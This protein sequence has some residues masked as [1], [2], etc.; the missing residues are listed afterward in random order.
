MDTEFMKLPI[1]VVVITKDESCNIERCL[2]SIPWASELLVVDSDSSDDTVSKAQALG[3]RVLIEPWRGFG[4]QKAFAARAATHDWILSLDA[5]EALSPE[6]AHEI[7]QRFPTLDP[8]VGY[9]MPRQSY[10]LG[11]WIR[12][13][14]W[15]PD[16]QLR[17]FHRG[18]SMWNEAAIHEQVICPRR[19]RLQNRLLHYVFG[20]LAEQI[21]TNNRYSTLQAENLASQGKRFS[22]AKLLLKP[23]S[24]FVECY[25]LKLGLLDGLAGF[26]IAVGAGY[27]VFIR[28]AKLWEKQQCSK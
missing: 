6:L 5:D 21:E 23:T 24:K 28:W 27:S 18:S 14:G 2:R 22:L 4:A 16:A 7:V 9:E 12:Y 11:R 13:G 8:Q 20:S 1:S 19:E 3:A 10:H 25:F 15:Y 26:V 17:L